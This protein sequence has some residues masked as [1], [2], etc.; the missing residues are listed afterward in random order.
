MSSGLSF[1]SFYTWGKSIDEASD[2]GTA[3]GVTFYNR[4]LDKARS[5]YDV[6]HR[7]IT[8]AIW[9]LPFGKGKRFMSND[10]VVTKI[11]GNWQLAAIQTAETGIPINFLHNGRLPG[12]TNVYLPGQLR[13]DMA[14]GKTYE[15]IQ[16]DWDRQGSLPAYRSLRRAVGRHQRVCH[17]GFVYGGTGGTEHPQRTWHVLAPVRLIQA[18]PHHRAYQGN[19]AR[20]IHSAVQVSLLL[21][22]VRSGSDGGLRQSANLRQD[23]GPARRI[24][25]PRRENDDDGDL[26]AGVLE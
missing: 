7:W 23:H 9:D 15:D 20:R 26:Q 16:L 21:P 22:A 13:P 17:S 5:N 1:T 11:L 14:P 4:R 25:R 18:H 2:D 3:T 19:V 10:S 24:L 12:R 8:Y 6:A